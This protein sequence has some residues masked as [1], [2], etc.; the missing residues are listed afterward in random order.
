[1]IVLWIISLS[2]AAIWLL[3]V[4]R[5]LA[6]YRATPRLVP[7]PGQPAPASVSVIVPARDEAGN[8]GRCLESL[9]A[10]EPPVLEILVID[11]RSSDDTPRIVEEFA[12]RDA[13]VR[14]LSAPEPPPGWTGKCHALVFGVEQGKPRGDWLL[15]T[16]ADTRHHPR[17]IAA[18]LDYARTESLDLLTL[19]PHLE[20]GSF[21]ERVVQPSVAALIALFNRPSRVNDRSRPDVFAN[22]QFLLCP[23]AAP[24]RG[25][26]PGAAT[27]MGRAPVAGARARRAAGF[28][29]RLAMGLDLFS[30]RMYRS[31]A[32]L[33]SGWTKNFHLILRSRPGRVL[34]ATAASL[35]LSL[36]PP[37]AAA[38]ALAA[39]ATGT[40]HPAMAATV[41]GLYGLVLSLQTLLRALNRWYP[42]YAAL[43]PLGNLLAVFILL[44]S[45]RLHRSGRSVR[46]KGRE[47]WD[48]KG[49]GE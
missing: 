29:M 1:M 20:A 15:F 28:E 35:A 45:A 13:R 42:A 18:A 11:D 23:F 24:R 38:F 32:E 37:I 44:R 48:E 7:R 16:D 14:L 27:A 6:E 5:N 26:A 47:V 22:G 17:G 4:A 46:W 9:L 10:Q 49:P 19:I 25:G 3:V 41:V 40:G 33:I 21:W 30:T 34:L 36:W 12:R 39:L 43:A 8:I 2:V 31:L